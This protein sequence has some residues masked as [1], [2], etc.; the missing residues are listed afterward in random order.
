VRAVSAADWSGAAIKSYVS[1]PMALKSIRTVPATLL[2]KIPQLI[3][4][5]A[6]GKIG[7]TD[8]V[9]LADVER[10]GAVTTMLMI[11]APDSEKIQR[12][13]DPS[14]FVEMVGALAV[15]N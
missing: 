13:L 1:Q 9:L 3:Q 7:P 12:V 14:S 4:R 2:A 10:A 5:R 6:F 8:V 11:V 15:L